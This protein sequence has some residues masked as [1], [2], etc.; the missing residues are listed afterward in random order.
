MERQQK[1]GAEAYRAEQ[2]EKIH[3][4]DWLLKNCNDGRKKTFYCL[5]VNLLGLEEIKKVTEQAKSDEKFQE[6]PIKE[7]AAC[8]AGQFQKAADRQGI[9]LKLRKKK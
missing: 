7:K 6:M 9:L 8:M 2:E 4:L 5:A 3:I 1:I